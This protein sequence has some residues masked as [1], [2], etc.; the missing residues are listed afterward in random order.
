MKVKN[1]AYVSRRTFLQT[2]LAASVAPYIIPARALGLEGTAPSE[3]IT[4]G[5]IGVNGMGTSDMRSFL[6]LDDAQVVAVCDVDATNRERAKKIVE[7]HYATQA[8]GT[9]KGCATYNDFREVLA[10]PDID[11]VC[12][13]TPDHWHVLISIAA[14]KAGKDIYCEKPLSRTIA[15]GRALVNA[16]DQYGRVFQTGTQLRSMRSNRYACELVR[17]GRIGKLHTIRTYLPTGP[18][19][20]IQPVMPVPKGFDYNMW[21][22]PAPEA[23]YTEKRCHFNFRYIFDYAGGPMTDLG[24][25]DNDLAQWGHGT[26]Y[27]GPVEVEG[28]GQFPQ[29]SLFDVPLSFKVNYKYADGVDLICSTDPCPNGGTGVRFEGSDGWVFTRWNSDAEPK[30]L[31][32]SKI[33]PNEIHLYES[34]NHQRNFL[35]CIRS[36]AKTIAPPEIAHRS[37]SICHIGNIAMRLGRKLQ[38]DPDKERFVNDEEANRYLSMPLRAPWTL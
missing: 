6:A 34:I 12:I 24:A 28:K 37:A 10:R 38:W 22:G 30:S 20:G 5:C 26:E 11:A 33:G 8:A 35:D 14:A 4:I 3:R 2:A 16:M 31:L 1:R 21:L 17:N 29:N 18:D 13:G 15:E 9:Y 36:R 32:T 19:Y 27:T 25:H 23:P 7:E